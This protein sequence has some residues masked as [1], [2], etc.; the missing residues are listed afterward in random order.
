MALNYLL[1][2][3]QN[4]TNQISLTMWISTNFIIDTFT[5][6]SLFFLIN[7]YI[8]YNYGRE[9]YALKT[10]ENIIKYSCSFAQQITKIRHALKKKKI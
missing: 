8:C 7:N 9:L 6:K 4:F 2:V 3:M 10:L 1:K 5:P